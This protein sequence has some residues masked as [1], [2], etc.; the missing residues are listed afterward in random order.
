MGVRLKLKQGKA[1]LEAAREAQW[2]VGVVSVGR[3]WD[4]K[5]QR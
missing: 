3:G 4:G 2:M 5:R 1:V